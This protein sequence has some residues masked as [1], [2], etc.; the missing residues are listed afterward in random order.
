MDVFVEGGAIPD[1]LQVSI[2]H[3]ID[4]FKL[5]YQAV[6][7]IIEEIDNSSGADWQSI[8]VS[9]AQSCDTETLCPQQP[10]DAPLS[11]PWR[12]RVV[13][14]R[15]QIIRQIAQHTMAFWGML[16]VC[17]ATYHRRLTGPEALT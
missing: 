15:L 2:L 12:V 13:A 5:S 4:G 17:I 14:Q 10:V 8:D 16:N 9:K 1:V 3:K 7:A 6:G 11:G